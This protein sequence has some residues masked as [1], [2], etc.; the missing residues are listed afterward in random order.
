VSSALERALSAIDRSVDVAVLRDRDV[1]EALSH[2]E[3]DAPPAVPGA[4]IEVQSAAAVAEVLR[5]ASDAGVPVTP[6]AGGTSRVGGAVPS[7]GAIVLS[8]TKM[9]R[10]LDIDRDEMLA[11]VGPGVTTAALHRAADDAGLMYAPDPNSA[12]SCTIGGN[13]ATNA[14]GPRAL[15]YGVTREHVLGLEVV[16]ASGE[17][18]RLGRKTRK[19]VTGYDLTALMI[20]SEGTL[21]VVTRVTTRLLPK[22]ESIGTLLVLLSDESQLPAAV[23]A[24]TRGESSARCV[25]LLDA[26]TLEVLRPEAKLPLPAEARAMLIVEL[27]GDDAGLERQM[28]RRG[29][30][31][32]DAGALDVLVARGGSERARLWNA[33]KRMSRSIR[34]LARHKMSEDVVVPTTRLA[35]LLA[36]VREIGERENIRV[37]AYGHAGDG[38]LHV[39]FL[40]DDG[41]ER[42]RVERGIARLFEEVVAMEGTLSGEHG[43]GTTKAPFLGLEQSE[44]VIAMQRRI[45]DVFDPAGILNPGKVLADA[46]RHGDC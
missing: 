20:G 38:N 37:P 22:P 24:A 10:V 19:G 12:E 33:R 32:T 6:R 2:D 3:S 8:M 21:G 13:V 28:E 41:E 18:L 44:S 11:V 23:A 45:K 46:V 17:V 16:T 39:N 30:T 14:G 34:E 5:V 43:L 27:D 26:R 7:P 36:K 29:N 35:D 1:L 15:K 4:V 25:E 42:E 40:W 31:L 9:D